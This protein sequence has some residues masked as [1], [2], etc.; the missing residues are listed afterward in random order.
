MYKREEDG[1]VL[2]DQ[3]RCRG[4]R[5]CISGCPYKKVYFNWQTGKAEK[6]TL[7]Y[8]RLEAGM[9]TI[10]SETCVGKI[11]YLGVVLYDADRVEEA[12]STPDPKDLYEAQL[13]LFL[14]PRDPE[15]A[16]RAEADGVPHDWVEAARRSPV[17]ELAVRHRVALPL[18]PEYRTLPM[19]WYVPPLSPVTSVVEGADGDADPDDVFH[20]IDTL[21]IPVA[22]LASFLTAGDEAQ[23]RRVL[24]TLAAMRSHMRARSLAEAR[25]EA[26]EAPGA[27]ELELEALFR[28]LALA[29]YDER[30]VIPKTRREDLA[31]L[32]AMQGT[33]GL[34]G[35]GGPGRCLPESP[36]KRTLRRLPVVGGTNGG[37]A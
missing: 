29:R 28:L 25:G 30:F 22:Y 24:V 11:R 9:P 3:E 23:V 19:V 34:E 32:E 36:P 8:P 10:C 17:Y 37:D 33:C 12:A 5:M 27:A 1:I 4:W 21:R 2:V 18:H 35:I 7:C 31:T 20:L 6:C 15:V 26:V 16:A 14:D 13:D